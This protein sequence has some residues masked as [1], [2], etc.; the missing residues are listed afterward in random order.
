MST[1]I[2]ATTSDMQ[3]SSVS[4]V[5]DVDP[6]CK[7]HFDPPFLIVLHI[8][9]DI[10]LVGWNERRWTHQD[11]VKRRQAARGADAA[12]WMQAYDPGSAQ[13]YFY[14]RALN[15][16][17]WE[18]PDEEFS[19]DDTVSYYVNAGIAQ[20]WEAAGPEH[21]PERRTP[22][23]RRKSQNRASARVTCEQAENA[24]GLESQTGQQ[25]TNQHSGA[26]LVPANIKFSPA[27]KGD[28]QPNIERYWILRYSLFSKWSSGVCLNETSLFSVTPE[29][30][31]K[32][33]ALMLQGGTSVLDAFCGCGG[34]T[35]H[36]ATHFDKVRCLLVTAH[37]HCS[38]S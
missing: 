18:A 19:P 28:L 16:S 37:H 9:E 20:P 31:A 29:V 32:H 33:H 21:A 13:Y 17:T 3:M 5:Q 12:R 30:I 2:C 15:L 1:P 26:P 14:N 34:N 25:E 27:K 8:V 4:T 36:L 11:K 35:I 6:S 22:S 38:P 10:G 23:G 24:G 7:F